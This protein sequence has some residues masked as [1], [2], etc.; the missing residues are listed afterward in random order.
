[1]HA[2]ACIG[3]LAIAVPGLLHGMDV[4]WRRFGKLTWKQ[5]FDPVV[6]LARNGFPITSTINKAIQFEQT[7]ILSGDYPGLQ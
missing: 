2:L 5:L 3:G 1:M 7:R 6:A 4:A